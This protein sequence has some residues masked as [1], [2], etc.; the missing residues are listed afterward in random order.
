MKV[1]T[2]ECMCSVQV[3][4]ELSGF[5]AVSE[6]ISRLCAK[7]HRLAPPHIEKQSGSRA[8]TKVEHHVRRP[9]A[10]RRQ[11]RSLAKGAAINQQSCRPPIS[12]VSHACTCSSGCQA[13]REDSSTQEA[14]CRAPVQQRQKIPLATPDCQRQQRSSKLAGRRGRYRGR[15]AGDIGR[16]GRHLRSGYSFMLKADTHIHTHTHIVSLHTPCMSQYTCCMGQVSRRRLGN[17]LSAAMSQRRC[18]RRCRRSAMCSTFCWA[19]ACC[20]CRTRSARPAGRGCRS[21]ASWAW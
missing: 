18:A 19:W 6:V 3:A 2:H 8:P 16:S 20:R 7:R 11:Y 14:D 13:H 12:S 4:I 5:R 17:P 21:C 9:G 15:A 10:S 1:R